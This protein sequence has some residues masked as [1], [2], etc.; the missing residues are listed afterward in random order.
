[1]STQI[2]PS[3]AIFPF[4]SNDVFKKFF[5]PS[6]TT[7]PLCLPIV[8]QVA[9]AGSGLVKIRSRKGISMPMDT[10]EKKILSSVQRK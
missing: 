1:M 8:L 2:K 7:L 10:M 9:Q 3:V 4:L 6:I 5:T